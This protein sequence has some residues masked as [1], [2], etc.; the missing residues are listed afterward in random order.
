VTGPQ[1][2]ETHP[3]IDEL[4]SWPRLHCPRAGPFFYARAGPATSVVQSPLL[5]TRLMAE[6]VLV[7]T[8]DST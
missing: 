8:I 3:R 2:A 7:L 1:L 5:A 4:T 6:E